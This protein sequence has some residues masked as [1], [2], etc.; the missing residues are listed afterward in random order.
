M[1]QL[2]Q[3]KDTLLQGLESAERLTA[4]YTD[5]IAIV[6]DK[7]KFIGRGATQNVSTLY[8]TTVKHVWN[9]PLWKDHPLWKNHLHICE[10]ICLP[11]D[12]MQ[13]EPA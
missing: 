11:L 9:H 12:S 10:N 1:K 13:T 4:W 5:Q 3:E 8:A 6:N 7:M 2:E